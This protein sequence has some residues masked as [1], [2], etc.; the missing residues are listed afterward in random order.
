[1]HDFFFFFQNFN[2]IFF[3]SLPSFFLFSFPASRRRHKWAIITGVLVAVVVLPLIALII[4][5]LRRK[6]SQQN[7]KDPKTVSK[8]MST[9]K[10]F[11]IQSLYKENKEG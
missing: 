1:M 8:S 11:S 6:G 5:L 2:V 9:N 10:A 3:I 7:M 4:L